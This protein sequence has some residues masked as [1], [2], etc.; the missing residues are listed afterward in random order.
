MKILV[1]FILLAFGLQS[2]QTTVNGQQTLCTVPEPVEGTTLGASTSS[3]TAYTR[4]VDCCPLSVDFYESQIRIADSLYKNYLPQSNFEEVKAAVEFFDSYQQSA[5]SGQRWRFFD[6]CQLSAISGQRWRLFDK[7]ADDGNRLIA[8]SRQ[9][10]AA[11]A[12]YYHAVGLTEKDDI[13]GACEHYLIA[14]EIMELETENLKT[15]KSGK[16][17]EP[18]AMSHE[19]KFRNAHSSKLEAQSPDYEKI[20]F[21]SLIYTRLGELFLSENYCD[22]AISKYRKALKY[23]LLLGENKAVANT[24]KCLGNS[25]QLYNMPDSALYYYN[26]SLETNSELPNRLDVEKCIAQILYDKGE[27]NSAYILLKNNLDKINNENVKYSYHCTLG[28][29]FYID[30]EYDSALYYLERSLDYSTI[31]NR[32]VFTTKLSAIYDS[33]GNYEKR[34]YYDNISSKLFSN[35]INKDVNKSKIHA[36]YEEYNER[37]QQ[38]IKT[39]IKKR[40]VFLGGL[41]TIL[42][43]SVFITIKNKYK[44]HSNMLSEEIMAK[45]EHIKHNEFK[46]ALIEGKIKSKNIELQQKDKQ[47]KSQQ[48]KIA[49]LQSKLENRKDNL[50]EYY[51]SE[52]CAKILNEINELSKAN[53]MTSEL[54][55]LS[56]EEFVM[57]LQSANLHLGEFIKNISDK[58]PSFK[59]DDLYYL[60]LVAIN[61]NDKQI[62]ALFN[63]TYNAVRSR[64]KKICSYL[65]IDIN[66]NIYKKL[67]I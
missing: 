28:N 3:A 32:L 5:I 22:L 33:L 24:Y 16:G 54:K 20:R 40:T 52:I 2:Q 62:A 26:K 44:K 1:V 42:V 64:R 45:D 36:L 66:E 56:Q 60:C 43:L 34:A 18:R 11:K 51:Q 50:K 21:L 29:M 27:R 57:L 37:N 10:T 65:D 19:Q 25:Y 4:T 38:K 31:I 55:P 67:I 35:N 17:S 12:H 15:S 61:L 9:L 23:K 13:V 48:L 53:K 39:I 63:V 30:K 41:V 47:I 58:Y 49:E 6:S 7:E 8:E 14:L 59:K 46:N